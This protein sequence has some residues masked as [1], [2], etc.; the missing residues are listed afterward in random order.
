MSWQVRY[1]WE[2]LDGRRHPRFTYGDARN[3]HA[4]AGQAVAAIKRQKNDP[5]L[6]LVE[7]HTRPISTNDWTK[8]EEPAPAESS[9]SG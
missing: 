7:V 3:E 6:R 4:A 2:P 9:S 1:T 5:Y 8:V